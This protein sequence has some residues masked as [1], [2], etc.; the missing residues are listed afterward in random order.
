[1]YTKPEL[2]VLASACEAVQGKKV[3]QEA[4]SINRLSPAAY[5][6]DE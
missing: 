5:D 1:M 4:D 3:G 6:E 2:V